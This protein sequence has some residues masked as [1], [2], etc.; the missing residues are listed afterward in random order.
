MHVIHL[1]KQRC[2][3]LQNE[4]KEEVG[5]IDYKVGTKGRLF[6]V[7]TEVK[8]MYQGHGYAV[9]LLDALA[10]FARET[11]QKIVPI[12]AFSKKKFKELPSVYADVE[13]PPL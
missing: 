6:A 3:I 9:Q 7:H 4:E 8:P 5:R 2:F 12:C 13:A 1:E 10:D 11:N